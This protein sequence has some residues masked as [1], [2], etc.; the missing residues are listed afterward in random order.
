MSIGFC[1]GFA[2]EPLMRIDLDLVR[3]VAQAGYEYIE[4]PLMSIA[5]LEPQPFRELQA[6][7][8]DLCIHTPCACNLFPA[9]IRTN[10]PDVDAK[11]VASYLKLALGR[12]SQL[13]VSQ[14]VYGSGASRM[15]PPQYTTQQGHDVLVSV[16]HG[17]IL[18]V[19]RDMGISVLIEPL[20][21]GEC[22]IINTVQDG[23][24]LVNEIAD[25]IFGL[26]A[27]LY[28]M[29]LN[30]EDPAILGELAPRLRHVHLC[31]QERSLPTSG[32]DPYI[33]TC[34]QLLKAGGYRHDYSYESK[35][36]TLR[37]GF[38]V[39]SCAIWLNH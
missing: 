24:D 22:N 16:L 38:V 32:L 23:C 25:P 9:S 6:C 21:R 17:M 20:N 15:V 7:V 13:G 2:T 18:P 39:L 33:T 30:G 5:A 12:A 11:Q 8:Q 1:T 29:Q 19:A 28:H 34:L 31:G 14:V 27:D 3:R 36:G 26:M 10:G 35:D 4:F 37:Q